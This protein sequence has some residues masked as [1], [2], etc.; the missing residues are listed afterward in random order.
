MPN[1]KY[2]I[3]IANQ[4]CSF[5]FQSVL[6]VVQ[7]LRGYL[8]NGGNPTDLVTVT[9]WSEVKNE[10]K[11]FVGTVYRFFCEG[12]EELL[13]GETGRD[14]LLECMCSRPFWASQAS[15]AVDG[16]CHCS[17]ACQ[18]TWNEAYTEDDLP[19][20]MEFWDEEQDLVCA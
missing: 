3:R 20:D 4:T 12:P 2:Q 7:F 17:D 16:T 18:N 15:V 8:M 1:S 19:Y 9:Y 5:P 10:V 14:R 6:F 11:H 13:S